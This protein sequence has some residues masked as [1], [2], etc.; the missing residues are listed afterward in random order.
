M[1]GEGLRKFEGV[2]YRTLQEVG[3][4]VAQ[5]AKESIAQAPPSRA[6]RPPGRR[7]GF[8]T[9]SISWQA[10]RQNQEVQIGVARGT[11]AAAYARIQ[12]LGGEVKAKSGGWLRAPILVG[13]QWKA[14]ARGPLTRGAKQI[15]G[16][17]L[18]RMPARGLKTGGVY[19]WIR[20]KAVE[21]PARPYLRP[22]LE[23]V[24]PQFD[25]IGNELLQGII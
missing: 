21:L 13:M 12:E 25:Q 2:V 7:R 20:V 22:A 19:R 23:E 9:N 10:D 4:R 8:L 11:T 1:A 16:R 3:R 14:G 18:R 5:R 6:G 24:A 17:R 15:R